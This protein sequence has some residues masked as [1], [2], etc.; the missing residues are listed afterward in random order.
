MVC[1][2]HAQPIRSLAK[3][4]PMIRT[5]RTRCFAGSDSSKRSLLAH[6]KHS[7]E[8]E[9]LHRCN[10]LSPTLPLAARELQARLH[11]REPLLAAL[12]VLQA[13]QQPH[14]R[15]A[16]VPQLPPP[17]RVLLRLLPPLVTRSRTTAAPALVPCRH[18]LRPL[19]TPL[20]KVKVHPQL[21]QPPQARE[22]QHNLAAA[23]AQAAVAA[24]APRRA[25]VRAK[26]RVA[27]T[28][29]QQVMLVVAG[30]VAVAGAGKTAR[31]MRAPLQTSLAVAVAAMPRAGVIAGAT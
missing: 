12:F 16:K 1:E 30:A 23:P 15:G 3:V 11:R 4:E 8:L 18:L 2:Q 31:A 7:L 5:I 24:A 17:L 25:E 21:K 10:Q 14:S 28:A 27:Q 19:A 9:N 26:Q 22:L 20:A 6:R 13:W 29:T